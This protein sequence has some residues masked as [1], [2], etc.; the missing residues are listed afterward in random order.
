M[1]GGSSKLEP[2]EGA[3]MDPK[4]LLSLDEVLALSPEARIAYVAKLSLASFCF[5]LRRCLLG[6]PA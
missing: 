2:K 6:W 4:Q 1:G 5:P 3:P